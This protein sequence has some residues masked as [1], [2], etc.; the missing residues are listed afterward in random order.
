MVEVTVVSDAGTV[1]TSSVRTGRVEADASDPDRV[2]VDVP[3]DSIFADDVK[4]MEVAGLSRD[5]NPPA[6]DRFCPY[7]IATRA[8][9][10]SFLTRTSAPG[11]GAF[12]MFDREPLV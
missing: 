1:T 2:F 6:N 3:T 11:G 4:W 5:C 9:M 10:A 7:D 8:Q 12:S